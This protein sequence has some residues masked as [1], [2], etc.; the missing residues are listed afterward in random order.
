MSDHIDDVPDEVWS[1]AHAASVLEERDWLALPRWAG[2]GAGYL[3]AGA[4]MM[5]FRVVSS[6]SGWRS[7]HL[8]DVCAGA[9]FG[10]DA[11]AELVA[12]AR[13]AAVPHLLVATPGYH[14]V[15][16][17]ERTPEALHRL[18]DEAE[19]AAADRGCLLGFA[20]VPPE[21]DDLIEALRVRGYH[22][23]LTSANVRLDVP[24]RGFTDYATSFR[25]KRRN[26]ILDDRKRFRAGGGSVKV[27]SGDAVLT[28][29]EVVSALEDEL[30]RTHGFVSEPGYF[31]QSNLAYHQRFGRRMTAL[32]A[33]LGDQPVGSFTAYAGHDDLVVR[34]AGLRGTAEAREARAYFNL[35]YAAVELAYR[36][37]L[38]RVVLGPTAWQAKMLRGARLVPLRAALAPSAPASLV[39]VLRHTDAVLGQDER[40]PRW[41]GDAP[42]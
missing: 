3:V 34:T 11:D 25:S 23:G 28:W 7:M 2:D 39:A 31:T 27:V 19:S 6:P 42:D 26:A 14:T 21:G 24:G 29:L 15:P 30:Q 35:T 12:N 33:M 36:L 1:A 4:T 13:R 16:I 38:G 5:P 32:V 22:V 8:V 9:S 41:G 40:L 10:M 37:D 18:I 17:G 20:H